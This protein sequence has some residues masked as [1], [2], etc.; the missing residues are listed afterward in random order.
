MHVDRVRCRAPLRPPAAVAEV[1][2]GGVS[3][4]PPAPAARVRARPRLAAAAGMLRRIVDLLLSVPSP[5]V[6][7]A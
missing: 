3:G 2:A 5:R 4:P 7:G 1:V 6:D